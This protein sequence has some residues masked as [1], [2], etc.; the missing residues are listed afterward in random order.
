MKQDAM[1]LSEVAGVGV[2]M[3]QHE[4]VRWQAKW[5][6]EK[7][8]GEVT[9]AMIDRG[10]VQPYEVIEREGN[11]L[12]YGGASALWDLLIGAGNVTAFN[13]ANAHIG[14]GDSN[15]A[16]AA[17]QTDLQAATNKV[18]K[19]MESGYP[20]HTDGTTSG[21]EDIEFRSVF[22]TGDANFDGEE[23]GVFNA[24]SG[25][26][27]LNRKVESLGTKTSAA[28]WTFTVTLSLS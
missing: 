4:P 21:S 8:H 17:T 7:Y 28:T 20:S 15:T 26:R 10:E 13:N 22:G 6:V 1:Q 19:A 23:W 2:A 5:K 18:R 27:M 9:Q 14:V 16:A 3:Q 24:S 25:G 11:L 12:M